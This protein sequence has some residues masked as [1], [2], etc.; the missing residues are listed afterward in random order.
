[1]SNVIQLLQGFLTNK[2]PSNEEMIHQVVDP[3]FF[4]EIP[5]DDKSFA[6]KVHDKIT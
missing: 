4:G 1:M 3:F 5:N 2:F 6:E